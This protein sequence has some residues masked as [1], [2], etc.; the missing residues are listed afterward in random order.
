MGSFKYLLCNISRLGFLQPLKPWVGVGYLLFFHSLDSNTKFGP[1]FICIGLKK[2]IIFSQTIPEENNEDEV[3]DDDAI[4][5]V[6]L[7]E[8]E[9]AFD[10]FLDKLEALVQKLNL[11]YFYYH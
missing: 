7:E 1:N 2:T 5:D 8:L 4:E 3:F 9:Y 6:D 11:H 10:H